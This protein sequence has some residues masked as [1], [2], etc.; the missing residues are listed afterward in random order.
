MLIERL[1][2][3]E[4]RRLKSIRLRALADAPDAFGTTLQDVAVWPD[5]RWQDHC[6]TIATFVSVSNG[7][8]VGMV[9]DLA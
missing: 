2:P 8:D 5:T 3:N 4:W 6:R 7:R 9:R 1:E